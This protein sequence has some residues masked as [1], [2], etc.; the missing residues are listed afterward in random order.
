MKRFHVL[1]ILLVYIRHVKVRK[2]KMSDPE[3]CNWIQISKYL[4]DFYGT[5]RAGVF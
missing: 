2:F 1:G 4:S 3:Y 5:L